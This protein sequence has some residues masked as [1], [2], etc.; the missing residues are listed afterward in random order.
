M[1]GFFTYPAVSSSTAMAMAEG[2]TAT[3]HACGIGGRRAKT[4]VKLRR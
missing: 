1:A 2:W 3:I 4:K